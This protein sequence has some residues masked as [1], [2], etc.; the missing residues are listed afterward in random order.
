MLHKIDFFDC[1]ILNYNLFAYDVRAYRS[2]PL[3]MYSSGPFHLYFL[4]SIFQKNDAAFTHT[5][6]KGHSAFIK[7]CCAPVME[8]RGKKGFEGFYHH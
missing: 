4:S 1:D 2:I 7:I 5:T 3:E 8:I 6:L